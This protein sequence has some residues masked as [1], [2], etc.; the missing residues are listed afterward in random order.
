MFTIFSSSTLVPNYCLG[1]VQ[2]LRWD[3]NVGTWRKRTDV[4][5]LVI[6]KNHFNVIQ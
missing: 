2:N 4:G 5:G 3:N 6:H 1:L